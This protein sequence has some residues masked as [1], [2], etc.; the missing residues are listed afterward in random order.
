MAGSKK[1]PNFI[2]GFS[3][4][5]AVRRSA[6]AKSECKT[7]PSRTTL[8]AV[9]K[10][11]PPQAAPSAP[12]TRIG[13]SVIPEKFEITCY[14]CQYKFI[15]Q[16]RIID[17][18]C[19]KCHKKLQS[20]NHILD[21]EW[22]GSIMT[23]GTVEIRDTCV[24][25][26]ADIVARNVILAGRADNGKLRVNNRLEICPGASLNIAECRL[27]DIVV[28]EGVVLDIGDAI[29]CRD[30]EV[31]GEVKAEVESTGV[32]TVEP[33]GFLKGKITGPRLVI[34]DGGGLKAR[35][36]IGGARR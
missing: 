19:P 17:T 21:G 4:V 15:L 32:I 35:L 23:L 34:K 26:D 2:D 33:G 24:L 31:L 36:K 28:K 27:T 18:F 7:Q 5:Q 13:H 30:L 9:E 22:S 16:G 1:K 12:A 3:S 11:P 10:P 14:E 8:P 25:K 6:K 29:L 20:G